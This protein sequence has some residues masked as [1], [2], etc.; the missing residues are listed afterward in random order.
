MTNVAPE[1]WGG[2]S[3]SSAISHLLQMCRCVCVSVRVSAQYHQKMGKWISVWQHWLVHLDLSVLDFLMMM[4]MT[5]LKM[6]TMLSII[7]IMMMTRIMMLMCGSRGRLTSTGSSRSQILT[8]L[9]LLCWMVMKKN[10]LLCRICHLLLAFALQ[11]FPVAAG[12]Q[13]LYCKLY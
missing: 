8:A 4:T 3:I 5:M 10:D 11:I 9:G 6:M 1:L 2:K 7:T 12:Q 13:I